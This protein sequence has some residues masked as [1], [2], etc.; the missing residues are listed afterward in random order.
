LG[1]EVVFVNYEFRQQ[2]DIR[3]D[4]WTGDANVTIICLEAMQLKP[5]VTKKDAMD[6][7]YQPE[8]DLDSDQVED[9]PIEGYPE[10]RKEINKIDQIPIINDDN[11]YDSF[12]LHKKILD[13]NPSKLN[14][15]SSRTR[16]LS[17][18]IGIICF[19]KRMLLI[20]NDIL[21]INLTTP[22]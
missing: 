17:G 1:S 2:F 16:K 6:I 11:S 5:S 22:A 7:L 20:Y 12:K 10:I 13:K 3:I 4:H 14:L 15:S 21:P 9:R 18:N 8:F 19:L